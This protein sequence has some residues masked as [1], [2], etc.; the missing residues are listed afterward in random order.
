MSQCPGGMDH[1]LALPWPYICTLS[2]LRLPQKSEV[3][4]KYPLEAF[5]QT[6]RSKSCSLELQT[7]QAISYLIYNIR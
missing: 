6:T 5:L 4:F 3:I 2:F 7:F 1:T